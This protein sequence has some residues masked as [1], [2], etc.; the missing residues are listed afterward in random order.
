MKKDVNACIDFITT[1]VKGH[2]LACA[3]E[4]F[5]VSQID[6]QLVLPNGILK[7]SDPEK[8]AFISKIASMVVE[9]CS[10]IESSLT[11]DSRVHKQDGVYNY[12]KILCHYGSLAMEFRDAWHEGDGER[13]LRCWKL[14]L[15]HFKQAGCTKYSLEAFRLQLQSGITY[16]PNLANQVVWHRFVNV[17]SGAGNNIPCDL[18]NEHI[19]KQL[20]YIISNMG[21]NLTEGSLQRAARSVTALHQIYANFDAQS[22]VPTR[23]TAHSTRSDKGDVKKVVST[24]LKNKLL[25]ELCNREHK[26]FKEMK[27]DPLY[28]WNVNG[29][30]EWITRKI[31]E[32]QKNNGRLRIE[33]SENDIECLPDYPEL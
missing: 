4:I 27:P 8:L 14:F 22:G 24:V 1:I 5:G 10:L 12:A 9:R 20:K 26:C 31:K 7:A 2:Y 33:A 13:V 11:E 15:P 3:C 25:A 18:F 28:K 32:Y 19:N 17:K 21:S 29:T 6:E 16:S 23:T 30:K